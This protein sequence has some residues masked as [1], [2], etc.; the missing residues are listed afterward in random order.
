MSSQT[1][2]Y[3]IV[4]L[5]HMFCV[6]KTVNGDVCDDWNKLMLDLNNNRD[7]LVGTSSDQCCQLYDKIN[8]WLVYNRLECD[9]DNIPYY[10]SLFQR[11]CTSG[12]PT[13]RLPP[14]SD[15]TITTKTLTT[16]RD[17][18][19]PTSPGTTLPS[20]SPKGGNDGRRCYRS[21]CATPP[22]ATECSCCQYTPAPH[23]TQCV[24]TT[25]PPPCQTNCN[26]PCGSSGCSGC[27]AG[28]CYSPCS[29]AGCYCNQGYCSCTSLPCESHP[30]GGT[31]PNTAGTP[32]SR[33]SACL[34]GDGKVVLKSGMEKSV[35]DLLVGDTVL[36]GQ[37]TYSRVFLFTH[38]D[39]NE[40]AVF[41]RIKASDERNRS[42]TVTVTTM[43]YLYTD[44]GLVQAG[45]VTVRDR[46][47][48]A[49]GPWISVVHVFRFKDRG[50]FN[51][52][53]LHGDIVVN[54]IRL[55]TFTSTIEAN[56]AHSL[57]APL[58]AVY[59]ACGIHLSALF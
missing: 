3:S 9:V 27:N 32:I 47:L 21:P 20:A 38:R 44:R 45:Q 30:N 11:Y 13:T 41:I 23:C 49:N 10:S 31:N 39:E 51:P 48:H 40:S 43:H 56:T 28:N 50:I 7:C 46:I 1:L 15:P 5:F 42:F 55:S 34:H 58:R 36:V 18:S 24:T 25:A 19:S 8:I 29:G 12:M 53:T 54:G 52:Q 22:C 59:V 17:G 4:I 35:R 6:V 2:L 57:L 33:K 14:V 37:G 26:P 16:T